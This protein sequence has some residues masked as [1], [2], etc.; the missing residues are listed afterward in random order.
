[1]YQS[2]SLIRSVHVSVH[3]TR[4]KLGKFVGAGNKATIKRALGH[5]VIAKSTS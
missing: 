5:L 3:L 2:W 4:C 1:M